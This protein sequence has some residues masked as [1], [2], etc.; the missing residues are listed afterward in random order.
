MRIPLTHYNEGVLARVLICI[1]VAL[2]L[3]RGAYADSSTVLV[4]PF[5][6]SSS[7]RTLDWIGEGIAELIIARLQPEPGVYAFPREER[8]A[9]FEKLSIPETAMVSRATALKLGWDNGA[10]N[11]ITG[12][13]SGTP[14]N[15]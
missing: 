8:L 9:A 12:T 11:V 7:D 10:D 13:F 4:F 5:E 3:V 14:E 1:C 2:S 15:F 6:N